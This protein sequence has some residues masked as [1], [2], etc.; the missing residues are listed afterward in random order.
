MATLAL[1]F[2]SKRLS[3]LAGSGVYFASE[4]YSRSLAAGGSTCLGYSRVAGGGVGAAAGVGAAV[5]VG[6]TLAPFGAGASAGSASA[7][8]V[9]VSLSRLGAGSSV[10]VGGAAAVARSTAAGVGAAAG[11][12]L[13][14][15]GFAAMPRLGVG[16]ASGT[17]TAQAVSF[18]GGRMVGAAAGVGAA[19]AVGRSTG[20]WGVGAAAGVAT[21]LGVGGSTATAA[22]GFAAG[23][24]TATG[25][26]TALRFGVGS[27]AGTSTAAAVPRNGVGG[28]SAGTSTAS[29]VGLA[30]GTPVEWA[31]TYAAPVFIHGGL[32]R[33]V[34]RGRYLLTGATSWQYWSSAD[35]QTWTLTWQGRS[36]PFLP[37]KTISLGSVWAY[38]E[39]IYSDSVVTNVSGEYADRL[40]VIS[41][42]DGTTVRVGAYFA[43]GGVGYV[44]GIDGTSTASGRW[45]L[46]TTTNGKDLTFVGEVTRDPSDPT[47]ATD[48][49]GFD[50]WTAAVPSWP[51]GESVF[52]SLSFK[53]YGSRWFLIGGNRST[54]FYSDSASGTTGWRKAPLD[55][56]DGDSISSGVMGI[57]QVGSKL[58][59]W[60]QRRN[61]NN[62]R[63]AWSTDNG[64]TWTHGNI[65][66]LNWATAGD[67]FKM[68]YWVMG[69]ELFIRLAS[70]HV[71]RTTDPAGGWTKTALTGIFIDSVSP[72]TDGVR[73][74]VA[75][76]LPGTFASVLRYSTDG[77]SFTRITGF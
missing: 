26:I 63:V 11:L 43:S 21:V 53:K 75:D 16:T 59:A 17:A 49:L 35:G 64:T 66:G 72:L 62:N 25:V 23:V 31:M 57:E 3:T 27:A 46:F 73:V 77:I 65:A 39:G 50:M 71:V 24:A 20:S 38:Y 10:G 76:V 51:D 40:R 33:A 56:S 45:A 13:V 15:S 55:I 18:A 5:A 58:V 7:A 42:R 48:P 61:T 32:A 74:V 47:I 60:G 2:V 68:D 67:S 9:G 12:A 34:A 70:Q 37:G 8:A 14:A 6:R 19:A 1:D 41:S 4:S 69:G 29:A 28:A 22:V 54:L 52:R 30:V 44:M 36:A